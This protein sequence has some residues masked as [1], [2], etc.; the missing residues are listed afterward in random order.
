MKRM[1]MDFLLDGIIAETFGI[2]LTRTGKRGVKREAGEPDRQ[3]R[4]VAQQRRRLVRARK[5]AQKVLVLETA[6]A[7]RHDGGLSMRAAVFLWR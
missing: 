1:P 5:L 7:V 2:L 6:K 3:S 4:E